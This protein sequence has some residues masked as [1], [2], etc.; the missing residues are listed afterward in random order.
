[1]K[2]LC[3]SA[4]LLVWLSGHALA[5]WTTN[6]WPASNHY[7]RADQRAQLLD[8]HNAIGERLIASP[9]AITDSRINPETF[10]RSNRAVLVSQKGCVKTMLDNAGLNWATADSIYDDAVDSADSAITI[11]VATQALAMCSLPTNYFDFTPWRNIA[12]APGLSYTQS[13]YNTSEYGID[14]L[15]AIMSVMTV[16]RVGQ[17]ST[18]NISGFQQWGTNWVYTNSMSQSL[19]D[20]RFALAWSDMQAWTNRSYGGVSLYAWKDANYYAGYGGYFVYY[21]GA[22]RTKF[23][24]DVGDV[25]VKWSNSVAATGYYY[26]ELLGVGTFNTFGEYTATNTQWQR[27][28]D[29]AYSAGTTSRWVNIGWTNYVPT[30]ISNPT[31]GSTIGKFWGFEVGYGTTGGRTLFDNAFEYE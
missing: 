21:F 29:K 2:V 28:A 7:G 18:A 9:T 16:T 13:G 6:T 1:M 17:F 10:W 4:F 12:G 22:G 20:S 19:W 24:M 25:L 11:L 31:L 30:E 27:I 26:S 3:H 23:T 14:G 5:G 15:K 8:L